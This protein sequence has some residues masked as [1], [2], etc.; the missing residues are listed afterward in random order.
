M[1]MAIQLPG[2]LAVADLLKIKVSDEMKSLAGR[3]YSVDAIH[4][5]ID[6]RTVIQTFVAEQIEV[7][8]TNFFGASHD[9]I[10]IT[11]ET[12]AH[13]LKQSRH[14]AGIE[15]EISGGRAG[16]ARLR[17]NEV[18]TQARSKG[19]GALAKFLAAAIQQLAPIHSSQLRENSLPVPR[20]HFALA[21]LLL[22][23]LRTQEFFP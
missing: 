7:V 23:E 3:G 17:L 1:L 21:R 12:L 8:G 4:M 6:G 13:Q 10:G 16:P 19:I 5:P 9:V 20:R 15:K 18:E 14:I 2:D 11:G 22:A